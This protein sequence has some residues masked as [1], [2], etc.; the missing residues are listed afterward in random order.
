MNVKEFTPLVSVCM[1]T[2]NHEAFISEA[3]EGVLNQTVDFPIELVIGEDFSTDRTR[4]IC[5]EYA[6]HSPD[7]IRLLCRENNLGMQRNFLETIKACVGKYVAICEGDDYWTDPLKLKKQ[8]DFLERNSD[9]AICHHRLEMMN[10]NKSSRSTL[11]PASKEV[12][13]FEDLAQRQHIA[14]ASCVFRNRLFSFPE[15]FLTVLGTDYVLNLLNSFHGKIKLIDERMGVYRI[16]DKGEWSG[17]SD[18]DR[19]YKAIE[20][21]RKCS[22][23]FAPRAT[24][25]FDFH[26]TLL[27]GYF[28]FNK[29]EFKEFRRICRKIFRNHFRVLR[30]SEIVSL[31]TR[32]LFSFSP[33]ITGSCCLLLTKLKR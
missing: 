20:T 23:Y 14:T 30:L 24:V 17:R 1:I 32:Y 22:E 31:G 12:T 21:V 18:F 9:F 33:T 26:I 4:E 3:I 10:E 13:S 8:I 7:K 6:F 25:E 16:H 11:S 5:H 15:F 19:T 2:Y 27:C 28:E 29:K